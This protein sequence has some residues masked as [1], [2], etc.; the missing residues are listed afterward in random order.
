MD[1]KRF[2]E[3]IHESIKKL[4]NEK[5]SIASSVTQATDMAFEYVLTSIDQMEYNTE[6]TMMVAYFTNDGEIEQQEIEFR[7]YSFLIP[8]EI[9]NIFPSLQKIILHLGVF[10]TKE[11]YFSYK[12]RRTQKWM[13]GGSSEFGDGEISITIPSIGGQIL[14]SMFKRL[15]AHEMGHFH[16][17]TV[18][19]NKNYKNLY[20]IALP[21][22]NSKNIVQQNIARL[23]YFFSPIETEA[24]VHE[25]YEDLKA[26]YIGSQERLKD[27]S[28]IDERDRILK[29]CLSP[30]KV[31]DQ[32]QLNDILLTTYH[33]SAY[34]FFVYMEK[35]IQIFNKKIRRVYWLFSNEREDRNM[36]LA[37]NNVGN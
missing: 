7:E 9:Q 30:L 34:Q 21:Y 2:N 33:I 6:E 20:T 11:S 18:G 29:Y 16:Q 15:L 5:L 37:P 32:Q 22:L 8:K 19:G 17:Y 24:Q 28:P 25:L 13:E 4:I 3:I 23:L 36:E 12:R 10:P 31:M 27:C 26:T 1:K 35:R 14:W